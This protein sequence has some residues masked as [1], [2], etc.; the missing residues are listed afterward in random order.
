M[1]KNTY[2]WLTVSTNQ[3]CHIGKG[4]ILDVIPREKI[5]MVAIKSLITTPPELR[6]GYDTT[7]LDVEYTYLIIIISI[8]QNWHI[9]TNGHIL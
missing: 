5:I 1:S 4:V 9:V 3:K 7:M 2:I 8:L 6:L